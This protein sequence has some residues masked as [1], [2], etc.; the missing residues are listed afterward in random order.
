MLGRCL[1]KKL[2][3]QFL[4]D[5]GCFVPTDSVCDVV[6]QVFRD[7]SGC[8]HSAR[9]HIAYVDAFRVSYVHGVQLCTQRVGDGLEKQAMGRPRD[10][11]KFRFPG[12]R[13]ECQ[14]ENLTHALDFAR[15]DDLSWSVDVGDKHWT[16]FAVDARDELGGLRFVQAD[17]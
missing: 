17:N 9:S 16:L 2:A 6:G 12:A 7:T 5:A 4:R 14:T 10:R 15:Y 13:F 3:S 1:E 11:Q 8:P